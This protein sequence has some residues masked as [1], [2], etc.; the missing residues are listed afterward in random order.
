MGA[1]QKVFLPRTS[2]PATY[3]QGEKDGATRERS[4]M[5]VGAMCVRLG[6]QLCFFEI[7]SDFDCY[8]NNIQIRRP[9]VWDTTAARLVGSLTIFL[10]QSVLT[11][12]QILSNTRKRNY[13]VF[14]EKGAL[15]TVK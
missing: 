6:V 12:L 2:S 5:A 3:I 14:A 8:T 7:N 10:G 11:N 9:Y 1:V 13:Y 4:C 15:L